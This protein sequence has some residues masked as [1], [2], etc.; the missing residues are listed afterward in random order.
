MARSSNPAG[1]QILAADSPAAVSDS[2]GTNITG[3]TSTSWITDTPVCGVAFQAPTSGRVLVTWD[4][5]LEGTTADTQVRVSTR[6][7]TGSTI[8]SGTTIAGP[9]VSRS[10]HNPQDSS[11][12][13]GQR[14]AAGS[15]R[16]VEGLTP[17]ADYNVVTQ[18]RV[19]GSGTP[20]GRVDG[21]TVAVIPL[22]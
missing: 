4:A 22:P 15:F 3:I 18:H 11:G 12:G 13:G 14:I 9:H 21:R 5:H 6:V 20:E 1:S 10:V 2:E 16:V 7:R 19:A 17:G 8:D